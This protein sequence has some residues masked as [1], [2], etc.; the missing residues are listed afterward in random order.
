MTSATT[1]SWTVWSTVRTA[2][3]LARANFT[4]FFLVAALFN[5]PIVAANM[6][7]PDY[8]LGILAG[9]LCSALLSMSFTFGALQALNGVSP[10]TQQMLTQ[11]RR[12][13]GLRV[14]G[15]G[16]LQHAAVFLGLCLL[17]LPGFYLLSRWMVAVPVMMLERTDIGTAFRRSSKLTEGRRWKVFGVFSVCLLFLLIP[18]F[19]IFLP[20]VRGFGLS[21]HSD[22]FKFLGLGTASL[23]SMVLYAVPPLIYV[24]LREEKEG[25]TVA[26]L[27]M[28]LN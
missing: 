12:Q 28:S 19:L 10:D 23:I 13:N 8:G 9:M 1:L 26:E 16:C 6:I 3:G 15:F 24:R 7:A 27:A 5:A 17:L 2:F 20:F 4:T 18:Y 25:A 22:A 11:F 21:I 14:L